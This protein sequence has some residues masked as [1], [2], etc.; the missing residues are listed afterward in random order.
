MKTRSDAIRFIHF[1]RFYSNLAQQQHEIA[2][3]NLNNFAQ[4]QSPCVPHMSCVLNI[5]IDIEAMI[6]VIVDKNRKL[7][8]WQLN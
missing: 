1:R 7:D 2:A 4:P 6:H 3:C 5:L 8:T